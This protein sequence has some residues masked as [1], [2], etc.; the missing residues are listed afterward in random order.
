MEELIKELRRAAKESFFL[1][2]L[3]SKAAD[4]LENANHTRK[5]KWLE[6]EICAEGEVVDEWQSAKCSVCGLYH[7][8]PFVY[9]FN[10]YN[11]CPNC[12]ARNGDEWR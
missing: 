8:T 3:L 2:D 7:T 5:G 11:F 10:N 6:I 9:Y 4:A 1:K 12:G